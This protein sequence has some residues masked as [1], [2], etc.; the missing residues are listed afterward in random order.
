MSLSEV[1]GILASN[2]VVS[3]AN[4]FT[5]D[6][7][8][9]NLLMVR[10]TSNSAITVTLPSDS[11]VGSNFSLVQSG[12][13]QVTFVANTGATLQNDTAAFKTFAQWSVVSA[14]VESNIGANSA[15]WVLAGSV[16]P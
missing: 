6:P 8:L 10:S 1:A 13:G 5:F 3:V 2:S 11:A 4:S 7:N 12:S 16:T 15:N 14:F 9:H